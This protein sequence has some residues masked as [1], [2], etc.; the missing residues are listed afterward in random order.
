MKKLERPKLLPRREF[1]RRAKQIL[2]EIQGTLLPEHA[3]EIVAIN[4]ETG[5]YTLGRTDIEAFT[6]FRKRWPNELAYFIR[7]DGG[8]V[9]KFHGT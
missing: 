6:A 1:E 9:I 4:V 5:E 8:P 2:K 7:A 3:S